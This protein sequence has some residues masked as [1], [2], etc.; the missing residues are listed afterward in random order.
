VKERIFEGCDCGFAQTR[1]PVLVVIRFLALPLLLVASLGLS[2]CAESLRSQPPPPKWTTGFWYWHG[3][4]DEPAAAEETADVLFIHAGT[5]G[6]R[7]AFRNVPEQ[8][9]VRR[10]LPDLLPP[11]GEY[12]LV[13]R[14]EQPGVP[15][16]SAA[17]ALAKQVSQLIE[18]AWQRKLKVAGVQFDIDSP[19]GQLSRYADFLRA[20]RKE[21]P[22]GTG[23]SI[24]ALLD[25][26]RDGTR[27][28]DV[29]KETDEFV[30]QFYDVV[31][32]GGSEDFRAIGAEIDPVRWAPKFNRFGKRFRIGVSMFGRAR[33]APREDPSQPRYGTRLFSDLTPI[34]IA[35]DPGFKLQASHSEANELVLSYR[36]TRKA[37]IGYNDFQPGDAVEFI[38]PTPE[39]IRRA[40]QSARQL[41]GICAGI[42]FFRWPGSR[43]NLVMQPDK[44]LIAAGLRPREQKAV[45][46]ELV[47]GHCAAV[48]CVD[49]YLV[50][51]GAFSSKS[52]SLSHWQ[53][54]RA[55]VFF[56]S[57]TCARSDGRPFGSGNDAPSVFRTEPHAART[58]DYR[59]SR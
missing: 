34:D 13:F 42:V 17:P 25:W 38:L 35:S 18:D 37:H 4:S 47:D 28:G 5:I 29:I 46:V 7:E 48:S 22:A 49:L 39:A 51:A 58:R 27:V 23:I 10:E 41:R 44:A 56:G 2:G 52:S 57:G 11:A 33:F 45:G 3:N 26:F 14:E 40:V 19:T 30:P 59:D 8:W 15:D 43:E 9:F 20:V 31:A 53:L 6:K 16:V 21:L 12:W 54:D 36:A 1:Y 32:T 55:G 24:T 50:N